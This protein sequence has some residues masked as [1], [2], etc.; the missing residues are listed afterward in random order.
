VKK[1]VVSKTY[2]HICFVTAENK[3]E[4]KK[5]ANPSGIPSCIITEVKKI[6]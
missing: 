5:K 3:K 1:Y 2:H 4:A 6:A